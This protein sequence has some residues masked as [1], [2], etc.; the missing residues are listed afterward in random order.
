MQAAC[1]GFLAAIEGGSPHTMD[2]Y[3]RD[4][5]DFAAFAADRGVTAPDKVTS[6][7]VRAWMRAL[8]ERG[9]APATVARRLSAVR[10]LFEHLLQRERV[11]L[12][13][14]RS[15]RT[16]R[17][18]RRLPGVLDPEDV[19]ALLDAPPTQGFMGLRDRAIL[20]VLYSAGLRVAEAVGLDTSDI[21]DLGGTVRV[22]G[23]GAKERLGHLGGPAAR[24]LE[25]WMPARASRLHRLDSTER[26]LFIGSRGTRLTTRSVRRMTDKQARAAGLSQHVTPHMLRHSFATHMLR[27]GADLRIVQEMLGHANLSTTQVYTHVD[28]EHLREVYAKA[29]PRAR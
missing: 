20:E 27:N 5:G 6:V 16:P 9:L 3:R 1:D 17:R 8:R 29:H 11:A 26:A 12:N 15:V 28:L 14:A 23:K 18:G 19:D 24:A 22:M 7:L 21:D 25:A 10:S 2:A 4:L 13:P